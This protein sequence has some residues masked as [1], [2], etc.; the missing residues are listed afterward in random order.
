MERSNQVEKHQN[1]T[2]TMLHEYVSL[3]HISTKTAVMKGSS[4]ACYTV[5]LTKNNVD[6]E[7]CAIYNIIS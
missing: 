4:E 6:T 2:A 3:R 5:K 7:N 1:H